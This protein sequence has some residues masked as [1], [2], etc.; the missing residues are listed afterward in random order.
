VG[1]DKGGSTRSP[2]GA[3][4]LGD[5]LGLKPTVTCPAFGGIC[6]R[7]KR[8]KKEERNALLDRTP[9]YILF[10]APS[11]LWD[12]PKGGTGLLL[13]EGVNQLDC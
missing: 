2:Q 12:G 3:E 8:S 1:W 4:L 11:H 5:V 13:K 7:Q 6:L 10:F 9:F